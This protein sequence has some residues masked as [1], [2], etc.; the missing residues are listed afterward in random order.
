[1]V[2][3]NKLQFLQI[4]AEN[5]M[6]WVQCPLAVR[7]SVS[8]SSGWSLAS[9]ARLNAH[10][11]ISTWSRTQP[12]WVT[13]QGLR[14]GWHQLDTSPWMGWFDFEGMQPLLPSVA[15]AYGC[16]VILGERV[17]KHWN[18]LPNEMVEAPSLE[19]FKSLDMALSAIVWFI[20]WSLVTGWTQ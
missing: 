9:G 2:G 14:A 1:M 19:I 8:S 7:D 12:G 10:P 11:S 5:C 15:L 20:R 6:A 18:G 17:I 4:I 13:K 3:N 16:T